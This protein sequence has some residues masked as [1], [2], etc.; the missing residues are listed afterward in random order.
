MPRIPQ[1]IIVKGKISHSWFKR[2]VHSSSVRRRKNILG[3]I[4]QPTQSH[5]WKLR[6]SDQKT[7]CDPLD[8]LTQFIFWSL[9]VTSNAFVYSTLRKY[10]T[11][12]C[13][14]EPVFTQ[15]WKTWWSG[16]TEWNRYSGNSEAQVVIK[17]WNQLMRDWTLIK[18]SL[19]KMKFDL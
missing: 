13:T 17:G 6:G 10:R 15:R 4:A 1:I 3:S 16:V 7:M 19:A 11:P 9:L 14:L 2:I 5:I 18:F 8:M 12:A